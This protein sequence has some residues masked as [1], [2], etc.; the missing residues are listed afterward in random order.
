MNQID[1]ILPSKEVVMPE[2]VMPEVLNKTS[3]IETNI[4]KFKNKVLESFIVPAKFM[5]PKN[6]NL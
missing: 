2:V 6:E 1:K 3:N 4:E 5:E